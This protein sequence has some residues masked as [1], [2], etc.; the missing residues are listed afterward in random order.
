MTGHEPQL[1]PDLSRD[2]SLCFLWIPKTAGTTLFTWLSDSIGMVKL[3]TPEDIRQ[4]FR[5]RGPVTFAHLHYGTLLQQGLISRDFDTQAHIFTVVR[6]PFSR[7]VSLFAYLKRQ[8]KLAAD[9]DFVGFLEQLERQPPPR[10]GL[11]N[12]EG[13]SQ[14]NPQTSWLFGQDR[15]WPQAIWRHEKLDDL[16]AAF[17]ER[18]RIEGPRE[19]R[20]V[21]TYKKDP[22]RYF[23]DGLA[24]DL[25]RR[26]YR[27]D[28]EALSYSRDPLDMP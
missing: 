1:P 24:V 28:F 6:N 10:P 17:M 25:V 22:G 3:K 9:L 19:R 23:D 16:I 21:S 15:T 11:F 5:Q 18:S 2:S 26:L 8:G 4:S 20:K 14:C 27:S 7:A 12:V 13:L